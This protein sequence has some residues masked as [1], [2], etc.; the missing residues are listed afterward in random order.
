[1]P[2]ADTR[3]IPPPPA[4]SPI[5]R[6]FGDNFGLA[7]RITIFFDIT[8]RALTGITVFRDAGCQWTQILIGLGEDGSPNSSDKAVN[9]PAGTTVLTNN[10]LNVLANRGLATV[11]DFLGLQITAA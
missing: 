3:M 1:M 2:D 10:Q 5:V 6:E 11:E 4:T 7:I 8:S 9:V